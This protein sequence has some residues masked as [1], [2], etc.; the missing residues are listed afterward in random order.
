MPLRHIAL[1]GGSFDP[2]HEGHLAMA[3]AAMAQTA[4]EAVVFVPAGQSPLKP[5]TPSA[6]AQQRLAMVRVAIA[7]NPQF[8]VLDWELCES[9]LSYSIDTVLRFQS[10]QPDAQLYWILGED[11][12][13]QLA[14]WHRIAELVRLVRFIAYR[15]YL[16]LPHGGMVPELPATGEV[17]A[18]IDWLEGDPLP[19]SS[20]AIRTAI[21]AG[22]PPKG[23][24]SKV[25]Q[26]IRKYFIY[27]Q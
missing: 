19:F 27:N 25:E 8:S 5:N 7:D 4:V 20:T 11:Q 22:L 14:H 15:R 17:E 16:N 23:L 2:I 1:F 26:Y 9:G 24:P 12:V 10:E 3:R 21:A 6:T 13:N 18:T